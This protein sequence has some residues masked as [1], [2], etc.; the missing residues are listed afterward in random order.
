MI[1]LRNP[2]LHVDVCKCYSYFLNI[3]NSSLNKNAYHHALIISLI[4]LD[5]PGLFMVVI[6]SVQTTA[7][8]DAMANS[9]AQPGSCHGSLAA[10][11][12]LQELWASGEESLVKVAAALPLQLAATF[13]QCKVW[14]GE[15]V[16]KVFKQDGRV[17]G[18]IPRRSVSA[19]WLPGSQRLG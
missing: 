17:Q 14:Q 6:D 19:L 8:K 5:L 2:H 4:F 1:T 10:R 18:D 3:E 9:A 11:T 7:V 15:F 13:A 12:A 16:S